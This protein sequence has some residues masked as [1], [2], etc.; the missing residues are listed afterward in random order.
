MEGGGGGGGGMEEGGAGQGLRRWAAR[1][2]HRAGR[3]MQ[4]AE[5]DARKEQAAEEAATLRREVS[6]LA[7]ALASVERRNL[8]LEADLPG[9]VLREYVGDRGVPRKGSGL[10]ETMKGFL[11]NRFGALAD[12][13]SH[14][15]MIQESVNTFSPINS[16][17]PAA[18]SGSPEVFEFGRDRNTSEEVLL[19]H[20]RV[21]VSGTRN[22]DGENFLG[23]GSVKSVRKSL[24]HGLLQE[25]L[26]EAG[27]G[28][29]HF[30]PRTEKRS[31]H[32]LGSGPEARSSEQVKASSPDSTDLHP[33][34]DK[35]SPHVVIHKFSKGITV[36]GTV[37]RTQQSVDSI[38]AL[39]RDAQ[40]A[41]ATLQAD[42][43]DVIEGIS[44]KR[45][46]V[47]VTRSSHPGDPS[48]QGGSDAQLQMNFPEESAPPV[49]KSNRRTLEHEAIEP[50][51]IESLRGKDKE[52]QNYLVPAHSEIALQTDSSH[53]F[54]QKFS[55]LDQGSDMK[56]VTD[57]NKWTGQ[58]AKASTIS[59]PEQRSEEVIEGSQGSEL[60]SGVFKYVSSESE[61]EGSDTEVAASR[62]VEV[63][64]AG[65]HR[66]RS[67]TADDEHCEKVSPSS[68][69]LEGKYL[70]SSEDSNS[71][72]KVLQSRRPNKKKVKKG[73]S[74][75]RRAEQARFKME[76]KG[77]EHESDGLTSEDTSQREC[78]GEANDSNDSPGLK[79][80]YS[81]KKQQ[82]LPKMNAEAAE[83]P[84]RA[85]DTNSQ[86]IHSDDLA[87]GARKMQT[88]SSCFPKIAG[89]DT[90]PEASEKEVV[91]SSEEEAVSSSEEE[92]ATSSEEEAATSSGREDDGAPPKRRA[93][94]AAAAKKQ[95]RKA[96]SKAAGPDTLPE[97]SEEEAVSRMEGD[98]EEGVV[99]CEGFHVGTGHFGGSEGNI[100]ESFF[101]ESH[102]DMS[103]QEGSEALTAQNV[104][105]IPDIPEA[106]LRTVLQGNPQKVP[107]V[108]DL[109][110]AAHNGSAHPGNDSDERVGDQ[111]NREKEVQ[112]LKAEESGYVSKSD[113]D[114][115]TS[116]EEEEE[117]H[118]VHEGPPVEQDSEGSS[119]DLYFTETK[120]GRLPAEDAASVLQDTK[121]NDGAGIAA[122]DVAN[123]SASIFP[124]TSAEDIVQQLSQLIAGNS[125]GARGGGGDPRVDALEREVANVFERGSIQDSHLKD[126]EAML[127]NLMQSTVTN[128]ERLNAIS[129]R[130]QEQEAQHSFVHQASLLASSEKVK[131][132]EQVVETSRKKDRVLKAHIQDFSALLDAIM[133]RQNLKEELHAGLLRIE[134]QSSLSEGHHVRH[135]PD[136]ESLSRFKETLGDNTRGEVSSESPRED[137][138]LG[139][140]TS[141]GEGYK[142]YPHEEQIVEDFLKLSQEKFLQDFGRNAGPTPDTYGGMSEISWHGSVHAPNAP[143]AEI[144]GE[145]SFDDMMQSAPTGSFA[146]EMSME[147]LFL[148]GGGDSEGEDSP[149]FAPKDAAGRSSAAL[150]PSPNRSS[151]PFLSMAAAMRFKSSAKRKSAQREKASQDE[152]KAET[153]APTSPMGRKSSQLTT[154]AAAMR[155]KAAAKRAEK[156]RGQDE[157]DAGEAVNPTSG[158]PARNSS[159]F[160]TTAAAMR[161]KAAAK[162]QIAKREKVQ[163][164]AWEEEMLESLVRPDD[165]EKCIRDITMTKKN[166]ISAATLATTAAM[167]FKSKRRGRDEEDFTSVPAEILAPAPVITDELL[168]S[169]ATAIYV[170]DSESESEGF[171]LRLFQSPSP[172]QNAARSSPIPL[173]QEK[174]PQRPPWYPPGSQIPH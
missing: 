36:R 88:H 41:E 78:K 106:L 48:L 104:H 167:R 69:K 53:A 157:K 125:A 117:T 160:M 102:P 141:R 47:F 171:P 44:P 71:R 27:P 29:G 84:S 149:I 63:M 20:G 89:S 107:S 136:A 155:F 33:R 145:P 52:Q 12:K 114:R 82:K 34:K 144:V 123:S 62:E 37:Q 135:N 23:L 11:R 24:R 80:A 120:M 121:I 99:N 164:E 98:V 60:E 30:T 103:N 79:S 147:S 91:S 146:S 162:K 14:N 118:Y 142:K 172:S 170:S 138:P 49:G 133:V 105:L 54:R 166:S 68:T 22:P 13:R 46:R 10:S 129:V 15:F 43:A 45:Q 108:E 17:G 153:Q 124:G 77:S 76:R 66:H 152:R 50:Q 26:P 159:P 64:K 65:T 31:T 137:I 100:L 74:A 173:S 116:G 81:L 111:P 55:S 94:K 132:L 40:H 58:R 19:R 127:R 38:S 115:L 113:A 109:P 128:D 8:Q 158:S 73:R 168:E 18:D 101:R 96:R 75:A 7:E 90:L 59:E 169:M 5:V 134:R 126:I 21:E 70:G 97:A 151:S 35:I 86:D 85:E 61:G 2:G 143:A 9:E 165:I 156:Q 87:K 161:F 122:P 148:S 140:A 72:K 92:A 42:E 174:S 25:H 130:L 57:D 3:A 39:K 95:R 32:V 154:A 83:Q 28:P 150:T 67:S 1:M 51:D 4:V 139:K 16:A 119:L 112:A 163:V 56:M 6:R 110:E 93:S 131:S